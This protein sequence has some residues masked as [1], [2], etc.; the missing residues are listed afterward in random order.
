MVVHI[1]VVV[2][3]LCYLEVACCP[4]QECPTSTKYFKMRRDSPCHDNSCRFITKILLTAKFISTVVT[5]Y[6]GV[7]VA[8][9]C[10][11]TINRCI[12][13]SANW[14]DN[15]ISKAIEMRAKWKARAS[16]S[17]TELLTPSYS[18]EYCDRK[19]PTRIG[20]PV[21]CGLISETEFN[22]IM[23]I[24]GHDRR[25]LLS[26][27]YLRLS[28]WALHLTPWTTGSIEHYLDLSL[29]ILFI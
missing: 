21:S 26:I 8:T 22:N 7:I 13:K 12:V 2:I 25:I 18:C 24:I 6:I 16:G 17:S 3:I 14:D 23:I 9:Q 5:V 19:F 28:V 20:L 29:Y 1:E 4:T 15:R 11:N 27:A 10:N